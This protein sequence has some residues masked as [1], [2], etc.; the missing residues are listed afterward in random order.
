MILKKNVGY[1]DSIIRVIVGAIL[2]I[3]GLYFESYWGFIGLIP[4]ITGTISY[5]PIYRI[6]NISTMRADLEREN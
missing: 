6:F 1:I 2:V 3:M 4:L 5:C